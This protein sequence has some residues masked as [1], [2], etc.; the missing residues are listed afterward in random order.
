MILYCYTV[1]PYCYTVISYCYTVIPY[2]Y[3]VIP[4][5]F[6][7]MCVCVWIAVH[8]QQLSQLQVQDTLEWFILLPPPLSAMVM[9]TSRSSIILLGF[10][11]TQAVVPLLKNHAHPCN[12]IDQTRSSIQLCRGI[13]LGDKTITYRIVIESRSISI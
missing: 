13:G 11:S 7:V 9:H 10:F 6:T 4:Y 12:V 8:S 1:I 3:T 2:C 5:C